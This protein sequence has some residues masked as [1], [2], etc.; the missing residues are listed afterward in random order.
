MPTCRD[1]THCTGFYIFP[2][3]TPDICHSYGE[4]CMYHHCH[5]KAKGLD[6]ARDLIA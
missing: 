2:I 6:G 4:V 1:A 5:N 3:Q